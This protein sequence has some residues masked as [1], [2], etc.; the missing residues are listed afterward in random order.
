MKKLLRL[1]A[2]LVVVAV[3][4]LAAVLWDA[5]R[6]LHTPL[7]LEEVERV[8]IERGNRMRDVIHQLQAVDAFVTPRQSLYLLLLT[9]LRDQQTRIKAGDF[10][11][12]PGTTPLQALAMFVE[13]RAV[14]SELRIPEGWGYAQLL[15]LVRIHPDLGHSLPE[16]LAPG[17]LM[18]LLGLPGQHPEGRFFP[19]T[20]RFTKGMRDLDFLRH[21]HHLME[22]TLSAE[23][24][25][26]APELP[27]ADASAALT[28]ASI[29]EK[30][31]G[32]ANE[33]A[34]I[35]GVFVRRL[36]LGMLLQ[37]DPTVIY[38]LGENF[39]GNLRR[40]DLLTDTPYNSY[41]RAGLPPTPICLPGRAAIH[42]ALHPE[43]DGSVFFVARGDGSHQFSKTLDEHNAAVRQYQLKAQ[44][45]RE[46]P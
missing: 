23:W 39:D 1:L 13:G 29:V 32:A 14:L 46:G 12:A 21:A 22:K 31:T 25:Q 45:R 38:G 8:S 28:M 26:R 24:E 34:R 15:D 36:R 30:E 17:Q 41:T 11:L 44:P 27:Y 40:V 35:A 33:R 18:A 9:R 42:A 4:G 16:E 5:K 7:A 37:T 43:D 10:D 20:Y 19:D 2:L 6:L 3:L